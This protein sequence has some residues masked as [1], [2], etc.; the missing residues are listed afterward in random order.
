MGAGA[1][2]EKKKSSDQNWGQL[3]KRH[4]VMGDST[5]SWETLPLGGWRGGH[6][7]SMPKSQGS[8]VSHP[9]LLNLVTEDEME[10]KRLS[11]GHTGGGVSP[12][13]PAPAS[14]PWMASLYHAC[15][16][17]LGAL[18]TDCSV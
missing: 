2:E 8:F 15:G 13:S 17:C 7:Q 18:C 3:E 6:L 12:G 9:S 10:V 5:G 1:E 4:R 14:V 11:Q 16:I